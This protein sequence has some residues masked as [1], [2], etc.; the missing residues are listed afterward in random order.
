M[1]LATAV[2]HMHGADKAGVMRADDMPDFDG[3]VGVAYG[4]SDQALF[5]VARLSRAV[6]RAAREVAQM[7]A[8]WFEVSNG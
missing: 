3:V 8:P 1:D 5:P 4:K 6:A 7:L 2:E